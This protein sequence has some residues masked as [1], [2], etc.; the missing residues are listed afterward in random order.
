MIPA[1]ATPTGPWSKPASAEGMARLVFYTAAAFL[2]AFFIWFSL[3]L[4][5]ERT[6]P[7]AVQ[8][9][10]IDFGSLPGWEDDS[11]GA[12]LI[13]FH[14]SCAR[15]LNRASDAAMGLSPLGGLVGDWRD[16]CAGAFGIET[17]DDVA[18]KAF[19][20]THFV[21]HAVRWNGRHRGL[22][23]GY[24]EPEL[25]GSRQRSARF[26]IPLY[27]RP[28][29]L[30][31][32]NLGHFR[33]ELKGREINGE[34]RNGRLVPYQ[35][36]AEIADGGLADRDL[37][38]IWVESRIEAFFLQIQGS[39]RIRLEDGSLVRVGFAGRNGHPYKAIG[40]VLAEMGELERDNISLQSI[41]DWLQVNPERAGEVME[42]N[43][44]YIFFREITGEGPIGAE[45]V[46]LTAGRSLAIDPRYL[47]YG[48][49]LWLDAEVPAGADWSETA[50]LQRLMI[51]QDTGG[52]IRGGIRGDIFFGAGRDA[53]EQAGR[54][55]D[56]DGRY[57]LLLP[58]TLVA[59]APE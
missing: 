17:T 51:A 52:A 42:S 24:Y 34:V 59:A 27:G 1:I 48:A 20:E 46:S 49:P 22:F 29:E 57:Y 10:A 4:V 16:T 9:T 55:A 32:V 43:P 58:K 33:E 38:I 56:R 19:F 50:S 3:K 54:M 37:E 36:H 28:P 30:V 2:L 5:P 25:S 45:N 6:G 47:F 7:G 23:T 12:A 8:L 35:T 40:G 41:R 21:P 26:S 18:A 39:G 44:S 15:I 53:G 13:A 11:H 14:K 31:S